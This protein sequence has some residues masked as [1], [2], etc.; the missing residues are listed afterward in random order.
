MYH[1]L[2]KNLSY[3]LGHGRALKCSL[4][5]LATLTGYAAFG[6][7]LPSP[8]YTPLFTYTA[9]GRT[10]GQQL[11]DFAPEGTAPAYSNDVAGPFGQSPV[12]KVFGT[13]GSNWFGGRWNHEFRQ[14][15]SQLLSAGN[16]WIRVYHRFPSAFCAGH[17]STSGDGWGVTKW[18]RL[19]FNTTSS[20]QWETESA[21]LTYQLGGFSG[22]SCSSA[23]S[24]PTVSI[25]TVEGVPNGDH[26]SFDSVNGPRIVPRDQWR[27][28]QFQIHWS[29]TAGWVRVWDHDTYVGQ[30]SAG[31]TLEP[32]TYLTN[33]VLGDYWNGGS[34]QS[35]S[36]YI[37]EL[38]ITTQTPNTLDGGGR[39]YI[40]PRTKA[41]DFVNTVRPNAPE[42]VSAD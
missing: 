16:M 26:V 37:D 29:T 12:I 8:S 5:L 24:S 30:F 1:R 41:S 36:W 9:S 27:A 23:G 15:S 7:T 39:P 34:R 38:I 19:Q 3:L 21:R 20:F 11:V 32:G 14:S 22:N 13:A 35:T 42:N 2:S 6:Q 28:L 10:A 33:L 4:A 17:G 31:A 25:L 40:D 18:L